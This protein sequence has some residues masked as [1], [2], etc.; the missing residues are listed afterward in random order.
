MPVDQPFNVYREQLT[1]LSLGHALWE[2]SPLKN[3]YEQVSIGDVGYVSEGF[4]H[5]ILNVTLPRDHASNRVFELDPYEP[6]R[7]DSFTNIR[8]ARLAQGDFPSRHV[9]TRENA[10]NLNA[11]NPSDTEGVTYECRGYGALLCLPRGAQRQDVIRTKV[12]EDYIRDNVASWFLWSQRNGLG[13]ERM[14]DLILVTGCTMVDSWAA[15]AFFD[16]TMEGKVS[17]A[18]RNYDNGGISFHW[19]N[20]HGPV[21]HH[22]SS[23]DPRNPQSTWDQCVFIRGFRAK[24]VFFRT[25]LIR[26]EAEPLPDDPDNHREDGIQVTRVPDSSKVSEPYDEVMRR[27]CDALVSVLRS[28]LRCVGLH[29]GGSST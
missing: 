2:P 9:S 25:R 19:S 4:F 17:L 11:G 3:I 22:N 26:A 16:Q 12:F 1:S 5:R 24:R 6:L 13:V 8:E 14:E 21:R 10:D 29:R 23:S 15:A 28:A 18:V 27:K 20:V 7:S